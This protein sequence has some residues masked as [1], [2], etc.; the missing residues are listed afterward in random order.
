MQF[1]AL[2]ALATAVSEVARNVLVHARTGEIVL[3]IERAPGKLALV[4]IARDDGPGIS[5]IERAMGDGYS[6][7]FGLGLGLPSARRL[8]DEFA[9]ESSVDQGTTVTLK[10]WQTLPESQLNQ[11]G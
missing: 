8:V 11:L 5:D 10:M 4:V 2:E 6:S 3:A 1:S 7:A 9:I